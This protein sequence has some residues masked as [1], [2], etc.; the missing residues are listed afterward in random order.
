[1]WCHEQCRNR[2]E[3]GHPVLAVKGSLRRAK[4][5]RALDRSGP[6]WSPSSE[7]RKGGCWNRLRTEFGKVAG[8]IAG[9][10]IVGRAGITC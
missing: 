7:K 2:G 3:A 4:S 10:D 1:M 5:A 6:F 8:N 9:D